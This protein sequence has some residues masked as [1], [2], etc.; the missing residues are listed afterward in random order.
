MFVCIEAHDYFVL[1]GL[2]PKVGYFIIC[3]CMVLLELSAVP[4]RDATD[5]PI[6]YYHFMLSRLSALESSS[7]VKA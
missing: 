7:L 3:Y 2:Y 4:K 1:S 6:L 5:I